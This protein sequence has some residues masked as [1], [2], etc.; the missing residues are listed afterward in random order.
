MVC[1][2]DAALI[3]GW[4][5][6][7][8]FSRDSQDVPGLAW[9]RATGMRT[10]G[11]PMAT[12][13]HPPARR[14][15]VIED[16]PDAAESLCMLLRLWGYEPRA[17]YN[18]PDAVDV[19]RAFR[20]DAITLDIGLGPA[21]NGYEVARRLRGTRGLEQVPIICITGYGQDADRQ[22]VR[23]AG[24]DYHL[25]KPADPVQLRCLLDSLLQ[26]ARS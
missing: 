4:R 22:L 18:G 23:D 19:A 17:V 10:H 2:R 21:M 24:C 8:P 13:L 11:A 16:L 15:L 1:Q 7:A 26:P 9:H 6:A 5:S 25:I 12:A 20:P 3:H 14:I